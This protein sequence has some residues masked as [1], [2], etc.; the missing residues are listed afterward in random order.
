[1]TRTGVDSRCGVVLI[2]GAV[3]VPC[4]K[5]DGW[6]ARVDV[7]PVIVVVGDSQVASILGRVAVRVTDQGALPV[8]MEVIPRSSDEIRALF[9]ES[10]SFTTSR[11]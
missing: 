2:A 8:V 6:Q 11:T 3:E 9:R 4:T 5:A 10:V 1:V 7:I